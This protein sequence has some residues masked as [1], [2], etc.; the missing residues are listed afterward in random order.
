MFWG[1]TGRYLGLLRYA[2]RLAFGEGE[3]EFK[4]FNPYDF[5]RLRTVGGATF[6]LIKAIFFR[7]Q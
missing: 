7:D 5:G 4:D 1:A 6:F 2:E 3:G